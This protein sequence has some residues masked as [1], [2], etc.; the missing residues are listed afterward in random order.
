MGIWV[1]LLLGIC[2]SHTL[3]A[4][5]MLRSRLH[6]S[7]M[8]PQIISLSK[9]PCHKLY[10]QIKTFETQHEVFGSLLAFDILKL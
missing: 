10:N 6:G 2:H 9:C 1:E 7:L 8:F 4:I 3:H 5:D